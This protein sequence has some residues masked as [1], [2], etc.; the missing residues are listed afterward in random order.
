M[1]PPMLIS[2]L[3][4]LL[5]VAAPAEP[6]FFTAMCSNGP[7]EHWIFKV[8]GDGEKWATRT[9][10]VKGMFNILNPEKGMVADQKADRVVLNRNFPDF[11]TFTV[12][13]PLEKNENVPYEVATVVVTVPEHDGGMKTSAFLR[14]S[15]LSA[16]SL[17]V[18]CEATKSGDWDRLLKAHDLKLLNEPAPANACRILYAFPGG[19]PDTHCSGTLVS[20]RHL[21]TAAHC[22]LLLKDRP[23]TYVE[24]PGQ[25]RVKVTERAVHPYYSLKAFHD[26]HDVGVFHLAEPLPNVELA[27]LPVSMEDSMRTIFDHRDGCRLYGYGTRKDRSVGKLGVAPLD[28]LPEISGGEPYMRVMAA[29]GILP[30]NPETFMRPGDSG[31]GMLC[32][33]ANGAR[34]VLTVNSYMASYDNTVNAVMVAWPSNLEWIKAQLA[35]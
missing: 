13:V 24:C 8:E 27:Q 26:P 19:Q 3:L 34:E 23:D 17:T 25:P 5:S 30:T 7:K 12:Q 31:G 6:L 33:G 32:R 11:G 35:R 18:Q 29:A 1:V 21:L 2:L 28:I 14:D 4:P 16:G 9:T 15:K 10:L 22:D 20:P